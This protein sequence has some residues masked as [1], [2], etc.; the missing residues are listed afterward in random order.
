M[1]ANRI[2]YSVLMVIA[3]ERGTEWKTDAS[4]ISLPHSII[5]RF[6]WRDKLKSTKV[7]RKPFFGCRRRHRCFFIFHHVVGSSFECFFSILKL[8]RKRLNIYF[9][10]FFGLTQLQ[11]IR[12]GRESE[13]ERGRDGAAT[14]SFWFLFRSPATMDYA[15]ES[16][17]I[18]HG[19]N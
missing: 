13:R 19:S 6:R 2:K 8:H 18:P 5:C 17:L 11:W 12:T 16:Y 3:G 4:S 1:M 9:P 14:I 7:V 15:V 10:M